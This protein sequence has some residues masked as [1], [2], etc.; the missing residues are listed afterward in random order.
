MD[1]DRISDEGWLAW[2]TVAVT[3][4][5]ILIVL[6]SLANPHVAGVTWPGLFY[7]F[8]LVYGYLGLCFCAGRVKVWVEGYLDALTAEKN[9]VDMTAVAGRVEVMERKVDHIE[10]L[11]VK[12]SE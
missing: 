4:G 9:G 12:I 8:L 1:L 10:E 7:L 5:L 3:V 6:V 2:T 11:L